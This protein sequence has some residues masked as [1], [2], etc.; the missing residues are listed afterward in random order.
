MREEEAGP[1]YL[2]PLVKQDLAKLDSDGES[3]RLALKS[4]KQFIEQLD[5]TSM[6]KFLAQ[7]RKLA[8]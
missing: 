2:S 4:L 6:P 8:C 7:V 3:R 5:S 1:R